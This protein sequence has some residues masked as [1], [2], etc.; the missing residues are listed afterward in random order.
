MQRIGYLC[1]SESWGGLEMNQWRNARWMKQRGHEIIVFGKAGS[2]LEQY[3]LEDQLAFVA[4]P[5]YKKYYDFSVA[6]KLNRLLKLHQ[7]D[8][9]NCITLWKCNSE[10]RN[11]IYSTLYG[12]DSS[13]RGVAR[14][15]G[16]KS[17]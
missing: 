4:V 3:C 6:R 7:V 2:K 12:L 14:F 9:P 8:H 5:N 10:F 15:I 11:G 17:K 1:G 13:T 16:S